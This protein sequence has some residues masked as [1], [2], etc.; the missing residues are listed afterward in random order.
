I[1]F[2]KPYYIFRL[3]LTVRKNETRVGRLEDCKNRVVG[4]L[5]NTAASRLL[6]KEGIPFKGYADPVGAYRDLEL[7]R[8]D[9]VLMDV[10][11]EMFYARDNPK[12]RPAGEP[13]TPGAYI[14]GLR[15]GDEA[16]KAEVDAAI[17]KVIR[18]GTL[19]RILRK[20]KLWDDAQAKLQAAAKTDVVE[21]EK[22]PEGPAYEITGATF[23]WG[24]ALLRL[25]RAA[26]VT[27]LLSLG[28][29]LIAVTLG[30]A[31]ALGQSRGPTAVRWLSTVY[32]EFFRGT[33]VLVQLLF[34]YF[35]LPVLGLAMPGWLTALVGLGLNYAAYE[36]Q[37]YRAALEAIPKGQYEAAYSLGMSPLL[38]FRRIILP[39]AL[40]IALPPMT[41]DFV[42]LF[43]D[44]SVAFAISVWELATAYRE[45]ANASGEFMLLGAIVSAFY[46]L[47]SLPLARLARRLELRLQ[48]R[49]AVRAVESE[50]AA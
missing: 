37:V 26:G 42:S 31:L 47:M 46:L 15:K 23:N 48:R 19:E 28:A 12:L 7:G 6:A 10:P 1:L 50:V 5:G 45:L 39:Q 40:R 16:L 2:S 14:I 33:P 11:M 36:S 44:T 30:L 34:L 24:E 9:A 32:V 4:T 21:G 35:G 17:D 3:R 38:A 20:W 43:K 41:N 49:E 8:V 22:K 18:D 27:V 13:T 29:M 25:T